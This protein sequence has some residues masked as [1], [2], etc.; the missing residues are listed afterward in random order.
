MQVALACDFSLAEALLPRED[1]RCLVQSGASW[2]RCAHSHGPSGLSG[3]GV[4]D[5]V[6][7]ACNKTPS[8]S[9]RLLAGATASSVLIMCDLCQGR[10]VRII[11]QTQQRH[12]FSA[13]RGAQSLH[14]SIAIC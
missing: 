2:H 13:Q 6:D 1:G 5:C 12:D 4:L 3:P 14:P 11:P 10:V 8:F 9:C 7:A